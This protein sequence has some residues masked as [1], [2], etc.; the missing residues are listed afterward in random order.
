MAKPPRTINA[1]LKKM[2]D[3]RVNQVLSGVGYQ[4]EREG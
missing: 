2:K 3:R 4:R 1:Y